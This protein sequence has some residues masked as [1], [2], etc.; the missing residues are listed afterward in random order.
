VCRDYFAF[1]KNAQVFV[2]E[3]TRIRQ[4]LLIPDTTFDQPDFGLLLNRHLMNALTSADGIPVTLTPDGP[5]Y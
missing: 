4:T 3:G 1:D 2:I 5:R